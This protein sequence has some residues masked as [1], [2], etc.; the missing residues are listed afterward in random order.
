[1]PTEVAKVIDACLQVD[2]EARPL[3]AEVS[4]AL[5]PVLERLPRGSLAGF[6]IRG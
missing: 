2:P 3:P 6:K 1:M 5:Q 4:D